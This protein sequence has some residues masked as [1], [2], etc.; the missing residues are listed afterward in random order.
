MEAIISFIIIGVLLLGLLVV[1]NLLKLL[2]KHP[3]LS[4]AA[5]FGL[6]FLFGNDDCEI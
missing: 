6:G 5:L 3:I 4:I 1:Y 2:I